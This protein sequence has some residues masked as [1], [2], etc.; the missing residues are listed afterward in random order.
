M[1]EE[2]KDDYGVI[3]YLK[4]KFKEKETS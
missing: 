3:A 2:K 1:V 4:R